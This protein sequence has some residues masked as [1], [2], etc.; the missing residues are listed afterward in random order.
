MM[1]SAIFDPLATLD[2]DGKA[3]PYLAESITPPTPTTPRGTSSCASGVT[4]SDGEPLDSAVVVRNL[5]EQKKA[6]ITGQSLAGMADVVA[7]RSP[8]RHGSRP[9]PRGRPSP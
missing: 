7:D 6:L 5:T 9:P 3:V 2:A 1:G 8:D 4:F